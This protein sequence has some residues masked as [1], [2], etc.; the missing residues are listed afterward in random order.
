VRELLGEHFLGFLAGSEVPALLR[1]TEG[2]TPLCSLVRLF[3]AGTPVDRRSA[4]TALAPLGLEEVVRAGLVADDGVRVRGRVRLRPYE[5]DGH[6]F[7]VA[8]DAWAALPPGNRDGGTVAPDHV[9]GVGASSAMLARMTIRND[10]GRALDVGSGSGVQALHASLHA[11]EVITTD[12]NPRALQFARFTLGL[13]GVANVKTREGDLFSSVPGERFGLIVS[14][15]PYVISPESRLAFRDGGLEGDG[16]CR[17]LVREAPAHLEEGGFCQLLANWV[18]PVGGDWKDRLTEWFE[19]T[20]C[21]AWV[22]QRSTED[23]EQYAVGWVLHG[24]PDGPDPDTQ[25]RVLDEWMA[26]YERLGIERVG[27]GL[28]T[29]RLRAGGPPFV[30]F[31]DL[32]HDPGH[33]C[34]D[35]IARSFELRDWLDSLGSDDKLLDSRL[36]VAPDVHLHRDLVASARGFEA[37]ASELRRGTGLGRQGLVDEHGARVVGGCDGTTT[38]RSLLGDLSSALVTD[39]DAVISSALPIV[40]SLV[41]QGFLLPG[42]R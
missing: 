13:S 22:I 25:A 21:D 3:L 24:E 30:R 5:A 12:V 40:R 23:V 34:G 8:S 35:D 18:H 14:N 36:A 42:A 4:E 26:Y 27:F 9:M 28:I 2:G 16:I 20:G 37:R 39:T 6:Q 10:V 41:E 31:E 32:R 1:R 19:G 15:P 38:L 7:V 17:R 33:A 11:R 29:M